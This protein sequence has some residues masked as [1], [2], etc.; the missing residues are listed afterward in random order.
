MLRIAER[1]GT[2]CH[3]CKAQ[4][5]LRQLEPHLS[6]QGT[7]WATLDHLVPISEGGGHDDENLVL[8]CYKCNTTRNTSEEPDGPPPAQ[9]TAR[10]VKEERRARKH[11]SQLARG[12]V[13]GKGWS[14]P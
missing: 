4:L 8:A 14:T 7:R 1:D 3:W 10:Q 2:L 11:A 6:E 9:R 13:P 5:H 12:R